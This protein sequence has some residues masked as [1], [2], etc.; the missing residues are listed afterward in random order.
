[1][2]VVDLVW[3]LLLDRRMVEETMGVVE[4]SA[5][6]VPKDPSKNLTSEETEGTVALFKNCRFPQRTALQGGGRAS[7]QAFGLAAFNPVVPCN[8]PTGVLHQACS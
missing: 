4:M 2:V 6:I 1:M 5:F 8:H 3:H 7:L